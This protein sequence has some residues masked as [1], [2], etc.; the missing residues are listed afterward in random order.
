MDNFLSNLSVDRWYKLL[1]WLGVFL[2][3]I[4]LLF[5]VKWLTN[6][7]AGLLGLSFLFIGLG[8]WKTRKFIMEEHPGGILQIPIRHVDFISVILWGAGLFILGKLIFRLLS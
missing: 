2:L 7:D 6:A 1:V 8:E 3:I 4:A 5:P